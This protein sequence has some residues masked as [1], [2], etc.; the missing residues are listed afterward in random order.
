MEFKKANANSFVVE[1]Y[2]LLKKRAETS[3]PSDAEFIAKIA[4]FFAEF[5]SYARFY[6]Y[7]SKQWWCF[8][9]RLAEKERQ[10]V[11]K[12]RLLA[13]NEILLITRQ[14]PTFF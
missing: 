13:E 1:L 9:R 7:D 11:E 14:Q 3:L 6:Q 5:L 12:N 8:D 4:N 2:E 10:L